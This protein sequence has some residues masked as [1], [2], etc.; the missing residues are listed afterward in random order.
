MRAFLKSK[1]IAVWEITQDE[2]YQF[3]ESL[4]TQD[5]KD[6]NHAN[7]KVVDFLLQSLCEAKFNR[8]SDHDLAHRIWSTL[9]TCHEG[10]N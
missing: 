9:K 5:A 4:Y 2:T 7:N 3:S 8:V 6:K 10:N 1:G